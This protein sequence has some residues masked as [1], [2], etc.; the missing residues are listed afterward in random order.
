MLTFITKESAKVVMVQ[1]DDGS[2]IIVDEKL[3][4]S[5]PKKEEEGCQ[6]SSESME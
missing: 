5:K 2:E 4:T 3:K 6:T 1:H